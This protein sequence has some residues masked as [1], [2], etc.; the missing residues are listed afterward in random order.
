MNIVLKQ[1]NTMLPKR[2]KNVVL[3]MIQRLGRWSETSTMPMIQGDND[4]TD[5]IALNTIVSQGGFTPLSGNFGS[6]YLA[7][8]PISIEKVDIRNLPQLLG[9]DD[10]Q[11]FLSQVKSLPQLTANTIEQVQNVLSKHKRW[12]NWEIVEKNLVPL[13][14]N[15]PKK[16]IG[17]H[18]QYV[19]KATDEK[20]E[21]KKYYRS[22]LDIQDDY[23]DIFVYG[24]VK[25]YT[26][27][28]LNNEGT[29]NDKHLK[30]TN[31]TV[32]IVDNQSLQLKV[33]PQYKEDLDIEEDKL[34]K[35]RGFNVSRNNVPKVGD[36]NF[37]GVLKKVFGGNGDKQGNPYLN[38]T[39]DKKFEALVKKCKYVA[40]IPKNIDKCFPVSKIWGFVDGMKRNQINAKVNDATK[41]FLLNELKNDKEIENGSDEYN[42]MYNT[43]VDM[44]KNKEFDRDVQAYMFAIKNGFSSADELQQKAVEKTEQIENIIDRI[45]DGLKSHKIKWYAPGVV[46]TFNSLELFKRYNKNNKINDLSLTDTVKK[47]LRGTDKAA[48][49]YMSCYFAGVLPTVNGYVSIT[50]DELQK[51]FENVLS[52]GDKEE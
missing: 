8:K 9:M 3:A 22:N 10:I 7:S 48:G 25:V 28:K 44:F 50:A 16:G 2:Q 23:K 18:I 24:D 13:D 31:E 29:T 27:Q 41:Q 35:E 12:S 43:I 5:Y 1:L 32:K 49:V 26:F 14:V 37:Q 17:F 52:L 39:A 11:P 20:G 38:Q 36:G 42:K 45:F 19:D 6:T 34:Q 47:S 46:E 51:Q 21:E 33:D 4:V 30:P 15:N 40:D